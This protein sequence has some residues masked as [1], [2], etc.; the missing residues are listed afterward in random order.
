M[1]Q[2]VNL[3]QTCTGGLEELSFLER[4]RRMSHSHLC[5]TSQIMATAA[6]L[7]PTEACQRERGSLVK[8][9][10]CKAKNKEEEKDKTERK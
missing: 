5:G 3:K 1:H 7:W 8:N 2:S 9:V 6:E 10:T 4:S